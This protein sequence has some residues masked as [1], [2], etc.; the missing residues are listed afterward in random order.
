VKPPF[1]ASNAENP[2]TKPDPVEVT[3][4]PMKI[5]IIAEIATKTAY[6]CK[7]M[8]VIIGGSFY[9]GAGEGS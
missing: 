1:R 5:R 8:V 6:R 2:P 9:P 4:P 7:L 3:S